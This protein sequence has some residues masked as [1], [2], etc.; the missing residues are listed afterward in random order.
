MSENE[1]VYGKNPVFGILETNP[2][3]INKIYLAKGIKYDPKIKDIITMAKNNRIV[4]N[5]IPREKLD[6]MAE[7]VHQGVAAS[8]SPVEYTEF[9][10]LLRKT[11]DKSDALVII[12]DK[13][14]D[15][16]NLGAIIRTA[17]AADADGIIIPRR[18]SSQITATV[19]KSSA[20]TV[21]NIDIV[22]VNNL[23]AAIEELKE[24]NY[25]IYGAEGS[26]NSYYFQQKFDSKTAIVLGGE[27]NGVST[28]VQKNCDVLVKIPMSEKI[29]SLNVSN[30]ASIIIY[31]VVRQRFITQNQK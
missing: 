29:N 8:V 3:R 26:A 30:A 4:I 24:H 20:G 19:E 14:E 11:K 31:E 1:I 9:S 25:W 5:E 16:H 6:S 2:K 18:N 27:N 7:G 15:P 23:N 28:L 21:E 22:Q 13:V 10:E 17:A 12:L